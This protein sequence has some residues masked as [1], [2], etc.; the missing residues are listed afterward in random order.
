MTLV[1]ANRSVV[2]GGDETLHF[3]LVMNSVSIQ[4]EARLRGYNTPA[5]LYGADIAEDLILSYAWLVE[6][7]VLVY[8]AKAPVIWGDMKPM[9]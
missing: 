8:P 4:P 3:T 5:T 1:A 9:V 2:P 6:Y 7:N